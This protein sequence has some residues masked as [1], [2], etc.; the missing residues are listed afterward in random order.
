MKSANKSAVGER[1]QEI[2][3]RTVSAMLAMVVNGD[4]G[5]LRGGFKTALSICER[6]RKMG[7]GNRALYIQRE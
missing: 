5:C 2:V 1:E 3:V 7:T 6:R 4:G